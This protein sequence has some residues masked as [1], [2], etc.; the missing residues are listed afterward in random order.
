[1]NN[2]LIKNF[3]KA[4]PKNLLKSSFSRALILISGGTVFAQF[5]NI[6]LS[7]VITRIFSA[8]DYGIFTAYNA[9]LGILAVGALKYETAIPIARDEKTAINVLTMSLAVLSLVVL[10]LTIILLY[11]ESMIF[12]ITSSESIHQYKYLVPVGVLLSGLYSIFKQWALRIKDYKTVTKTTVTQS[13]FGNLF[14]LIT[15]LVGLGPL[16]L[17]LGGIIGQ[18]SGIV[19]LSKPLIKRDRSIIKNISFK[20]IIWCLKKYKDFPIFNASNQLINNLTGN[21]PILFITMFYGSSVVGNFGLAYIIV[22]LPMNLIGSAIGDVYF[23]EASSIGRTNPRKL[24]NLS[25][26]LTRNLALIGIIPV[27]IL[28]IF[29]P[30]I[31]SVLFGESWYQAGVFARIVSFMMF[32]M[33]IITASGKIYVVYERQRV[34]FFL[35]LIRVILNILVFILSSKFNLDVY[36]ALT[37][38]VITSSVVYLGTHIIAQKILNGEIRKKEAVG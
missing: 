33:L 22:K 15:G 18:S 20:K 8:E 26:K 13:I 23:A 16:G 11:F 37:L 6:V 5:L 14:K 2:L 3:R 38:Y 24:K 9:L 30:Q 12:S 32:F 19:Q 1:M 36:S 35:D 27:I 34:R 31:F 21:L 17:I 28:L 25:N 4:L 10:I 7:P 29:G